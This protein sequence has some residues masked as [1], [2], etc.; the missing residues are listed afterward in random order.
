MDSIYKLHQN[1]NVNDFF[2]S[3]YYEIPNLNN[4]QKS[5]RW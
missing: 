4:L 2:N 1:I 3:I 5:D